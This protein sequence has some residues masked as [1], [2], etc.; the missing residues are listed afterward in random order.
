MRSYTAVLL[1]CCAVVATLL[2]FSSSAPSAAAARL[3]SDLFRHA[4]PDAAHFAPAAYAI[5]NYNFSNCDAFLPLQF[6]NVTE[7]IVQ[8]NVFFLL[9][10]FHTAVAI[11]SSFM[12]ENISFTG[13]GAGTSSSFSLTVGMESFLLQPATLPISAGASNLLLS[14]TQENDRQLGHYTEQVHIYDAYQTIL[15]CGLSEYDVV[16]A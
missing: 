10:R 1:S 3:G 11:Q 15:G 12:V 16:K 7:T 13:V 14:T 5:T 6:D 2:L 8:G 9:A 4:R